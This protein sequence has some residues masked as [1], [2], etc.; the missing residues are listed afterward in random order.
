MRRFLAFSVTSIVLTTGLFVSFAQ[1]DVKGP[2]C[3]DING[4]SQQSS[5]IT[6]FNSDHDAVLSI[7]I[8]TVAPLCKGASYTLYLSP[9]GTTFTAYRY[10]GDSRFSSCGPNCLTF[11]IDYGSTANQG[12]SSAPAYAYVYLESAL[13]SRVFDVAP[14]SGAVL[15]PAFVLCDYHPDTQ[16]YDNTGAQIPGCEPPGGNYF[17]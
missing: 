8:T 3:V 15:T 11:T 6:D 16:D 12:S 17:Q 13:G 7:Q 9:D 2:G 5:Y 14:N 4:D 1:A 10:P